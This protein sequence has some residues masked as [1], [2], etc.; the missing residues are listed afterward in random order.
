MDVKI[1]EEQIEKLK[2]EQKTVDFDTF[3]EDI[4]W[5]I[6]RRIREKAAVAHYP[7]SIRIEACDRVLFA[8]S[9]PGAGPINDAWAR[10]KSNTARRFNKSS[11]EMAVYT[12]LKGYDLCSRYG[13]EPLEY[14]GSGGAVPII[15]NGMTIG[16]ITVSGLAEN[17]DHDLVVATI[18]EVL[19]G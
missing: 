17:E 3:N 16:A 18:H 1:L 11:Y 19:E 4:A 12:R 7:I 6:G 8:A 5:E 14:A 2:A 10:R 13:L 9:M 15:L